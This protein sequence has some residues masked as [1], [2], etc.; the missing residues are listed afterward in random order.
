LRDELLK[1]GWIVK[2]G[3]EGF[4]LAKSE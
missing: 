3:K 2:D 1:L 4:E